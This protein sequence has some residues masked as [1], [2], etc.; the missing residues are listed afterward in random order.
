LNNQN[1]EVLI[2]G[3]F[4]LLHWRVLCHRELCFL[5][6]SDLLLQGFLKKVFHSNVSKWLYLIIIFN[7]FFLFEC[8]KNIIDFMSLNGAEIKTKKNC[9]E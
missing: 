3:S 9:L 2:L 5:S 4:G 6:A 7:L 8:F 1:Q